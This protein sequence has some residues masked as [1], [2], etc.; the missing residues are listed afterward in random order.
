M[1]TQRWRCIKKAGCFAYNKRFK[2][3]QE[4][5]LEWIDNGYAPPHDWFV[6]AEDYDDAI[7][8]NEFVG[9][10]V[11]AGSDPRTTA[12]LIDAL[13][14]Y[15]GD[16]PKTWNRAQIWRTLIAREL[17]ESKTDTGTRKP[18]RPANQKE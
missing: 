3:G 15:M 10:I 8:K 7:R 2:L 6:K 4:F 13:S 16:I 11:S 12:V 5:P 1:A 14:K 18:G 9:R 17:A